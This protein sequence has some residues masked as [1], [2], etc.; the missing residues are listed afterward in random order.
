MASNRDHDLTVMFF[1]LK[2]LIPQPQN[3]VSFLKEELNSSLHL[4]KFISF[5]QISNDSIKI[6]PAGTS[7][8]DIPFGDNW[9]AVGDAA[10]THDP[11]SSYG[12]TSAFASGYYAGQAIASKFSGRMEAMDAYRYIIENAFQ[13]YWE[14]LFHQYKSENRWSGSSYW[15]ERLG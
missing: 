12:I 5:P 6:M 7:R 1:T 11:I 14:K 8:L 10:I 3:V 9:V 2:K 15:G 13:A 4:S